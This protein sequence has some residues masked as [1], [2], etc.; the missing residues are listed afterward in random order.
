M[1]KKKKKVKSLL[2]KVMRTQE[3]Y[4]GSKGLYAFRLFY[5]FLYDVFRMVA[6]ILAIPA[7]IVVIGILGVSV[8]V[9]VQYGTTLSAYNEFAT[10]CVDES[11]EATFKLDE[12]TYIYDDG[13]NTIAKL[14]GNGDS[15]YLKY[16]DIPEYA[17]EAFVAV[18]DQSYW[19]NI[20][21]DFKGVVRVLTQ[22]VL[23]HGVEATGAST[24]TQQLARGTFLTREKSIERK[25]KEMLIAVKMNQKYTKEQ[26]MEY[27]VNDV[28]F[29]NGIYGLEAASMAYFGVSSSELSLSQI[30]YLCAIPNSP[31]YYD[32]FMHPK[33]AIKRRDKILR[34]M[35][36]MEYI[37]QEQCDEA[38]KEKIKIVRQ[39][40]GFYNYETTYAV[41]CATEY[42]MKLNGFE[43]QY[44]F[45]S[46]EEY[47]A[48]QKEY[49]TAFDTAK[50]ELYTSGYR[51][52]TA[53][54]SEIANKLQ[55]AVDENLSFDTETTGETGIY[56]LQG[57]LTAIDNQTG[58]VVGVIGGRSQSNLEN[59]YS[60][61]RA[62]QSYR[63]PGSTIKPI[64]VYTP[65]LMKGYT[66]DSTLMNI[67]VSVANKAGTDIG[68]L[69]GE[70]MSLR[71]AVERSINGCAYQ[72]YYQITPKYGISFATE[73]Q[74]DKIVPGDY[75]MS[76]AL[77]GLTYGVTTEQMA[78]AYAALA[79]QG[80]FRPTTCITSM[81][82]SEGNEL[83]EE[84]ETTQV[85]SVEAANT[86]VDVL[87]G[88]ITNGT[89]AKMGWYDSSEIDAAGKTGTTNDS[90]DGWF[91]GITPY[92]TISV[93]VGYDQPRTLSSLYG[94]SYP[95]SIW[96]DAMLALT[97]GKPKKT[98]VTTKLD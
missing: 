61:N 43:F 42:I 83:Y 49:Q 71:S 80:E 67:D 40:R 47:N 10:K 48:Y 64:V 41:N 23:T 51:V 63:Q 45:T 81:L 17:V 66:P 12:T 85:Y 95:A 75:Y 70:S 3:L 29:A 18:E 88:V 74:F 50:N 24:I 73:L 89:A 37:T 90:K 94:S 57:A 31:Q 11:S 30:A 9:K 34:D 60:L 35:V 52:Q 68:S 25:L 54:N 21:V 69:S 4:G 14:S 1:K 16:K 55:A 38:T 8:F 77:G 72:V 58:K 32:P 79:D 56:A 6:K 7:L 87:K 82:D 27:Y 22:Y 15:D 19:S 5:A 26:I 96:K 62:Y 13:G 92:Y 44:E 76:A 39:K 65:A 98:F 86:M 97:E 36:K 53:L 2:K 84:E 33:R 46:D 59:T 28:C 91:C 20:G 93:W 78:G